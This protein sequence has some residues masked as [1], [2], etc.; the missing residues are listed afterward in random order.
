MLTC[1]FLWVIV[2]L[3]VYFCWRKHPAC[4]IIQA[5]TIIR[6]IRVNVKTLFAINK[7]LGFD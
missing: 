1:T 6:E 2:T 3:Y 7:K 4:T 5:C